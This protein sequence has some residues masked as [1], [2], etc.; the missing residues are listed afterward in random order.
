MSRNQ[1]RLK[2]TEWSDPHAALKTRYNGRLKDKKI[3]HPNRQ[4]LLE[5]IVERP[6]L[7]IQELAE[8]I[9]V[10]RTSVKHHV[11]RLK[12]MGFVETVRKG[13]HVLHFGT[14]VEATRK[15]V[16]SLLRVP[17]VREVVL[18]LYR[19]GELP[20]LDR[21][22]DNLGVSVRTVR[23]AVDALER[24]DLIDVGTGSGPEQLHPQ[25]R[26][27]MARWYVHRSGGDN[28]DNPAKDP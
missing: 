22:A 4:M 11:Y 10:E 25:L 6:G 21:V 23:R 16:F 14:S 13:R 1:A 12:E 7:N 24:H 20:S 8:A 28:T 17:S 26:A 5:L 18:Y 3:D 27:V 19:H 9:G 2:S 15:R